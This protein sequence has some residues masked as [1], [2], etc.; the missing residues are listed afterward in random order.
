M[1][2]LVLF[3]ENHLLT[4]PSRKWVDL[5]SLPRGLAEYRNDAVT[6][7]PTPFLFSLEETNNS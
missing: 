4:K 6:S 5:S 2:A 7:Q 1:D 3:E